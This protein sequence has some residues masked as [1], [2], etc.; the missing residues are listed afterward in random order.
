LIAPNWHRCVAVTQLFGEEEEEE[1]GTQLVFLAN[2]IEFFILLLIPRS[3]RYA[4]G[5]YMF[6]VLNRY[7]A[8]LR[9]GGEE[10]GTQIFFLARPKKEPNEPDPA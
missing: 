9:D 3:A 10:K 2:G 6:H 5:G 8:F 1:T 4:P 7:V